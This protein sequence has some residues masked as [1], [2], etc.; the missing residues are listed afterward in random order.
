MS[1]GLVYVDN[2]DSEKPT[3]QS[4]P[5][6]PVGSPSVLEFREDANDMLWLLG[7]DNKWYLFNP[8][9]HESIVLNAGD[10]ILP[11]IDLE[12]LS[13]IQG[14]EGIWAM[15]KTGIRLLDIPTDI[16]KNKK[17]LVHFLDFKIF[18]RNANERLLQPEIN[19]SAE[20]NYFTVSF[21]A[22]DFENSTR[23]RYFYKLDGIN[24]DWVNSGAKHE[25]N[26]TNL[27]GGTYIFR[28]RAVYGNDDPQNALESTLRIVVEP[29][30]WKTW[31]F[32]TLIALI[33]CI[34]AY[35]VFRLKIDAVRHEAELKSEFNNRLAEVRIS[36]L[37]AQM[38]P[39]FIFNCMNTVEG[40][41][42]ENKK[43]EA[44][45]FLQK[46]SKLIRLVLENAQY[47]VVPLEQD[48]TALEMYIDL[49]KVRT[50]GKFNSEIIVDESLMDFEIP[51]MFL[52]PFVENAILHGLRHRDT[53]GGY[54]RINISKK[55]QHTFECIIE[56]N[57]IGRKNAKLLNKQ[58]ENL[59]KT[60]LGLKVTR[61]RL[62]IFSPNANLL[63]EDAFP[64]KK[65]A[66]F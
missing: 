46:F 49:E 51:P 16:F 42:L 9:T 22:S 15:T 43:W 37:R 64:N 14:Q 45:A 54:L 57:G 20:E 61:E 11:D 62:H 39:H 53:E 33:F 4:F 8:D 2:P 66:W 3:F 5:L 24:A 12:N 17:L 29:P 65:N 7:S 40:F 23:I 6:T 35:T 28:V 21:S 10:D 25:V 58:T 18:E 31:W 13:L 38:N 60:S 50:E 59:H 32:R 63:T 44:S 27:D 48:L 36:A 41:V 56:D 26:Y 1:D 30:F 34:I 19:L 47:N 55:D 52:Q